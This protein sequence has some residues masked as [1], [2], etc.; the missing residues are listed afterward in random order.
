VTEPPTDENGALPTDE[1]L[2]GRHFGPSPLPGRINAGAATHPGLV[3]SNNEDHYAVVERRRT[4]SVL[5]T[6]LPDGFLS[7]TDDTAYSLIVADGMGGR[8]FGELASAMVIRTAWNLGRQSVK[9]TWIVT[10]REV[11]DLKER[12]EIIFRQMDQSLRD[13]ARVEPKSIGMGTTVT[14]AYIVGAEAFIAHV[15]DSRAYLYRA[16]QLAKVTRDH[17]LAQ[18][19]LDLGVPVLLAS[20]HHTLTNCLGASDRVLELE[21]HHLRLVD[22]DRLLLCTDGL[23]DMVPDDEIAKV[24]AGSEG[25]QK[26]AQALVDLAL[27][28]GGRDNVT[29]IVAQLQ[30]GPVT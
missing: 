12:L 9:W 17:T 1:D 5:L 16:G 24:F 28:R 29:V 20:W 26:T 7:G 14:G 10:D 27:E 6:N 2:F 3:R 30:L 15:G 8:A 11:E 21:F 23:T 4:R 13:Y 22:G 19:C 25:S 18:Q